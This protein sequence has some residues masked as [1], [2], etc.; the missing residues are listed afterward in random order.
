MTGFY[1][2]L[3]LPRIEEFAQRNGFY[4]SEWKSDVLAD[5]TNEGA[6]CVER[7][8]DPRD[9]KKTVWHCYGRR[10]VLHCVADTRAEDT[11]FAIGLL[12]GPMS[13]FG[14]RP[15][16][17]PFQ[18]PGP[19]GLHTFGRRSTT[20]ISVTEHL[21]KCESARLAASAPRS[22]ASAPPESAR[23]DPPTVTSASAPLNV[24]NPTHVVSIGVARSGSER[25]ARTGATG[26]DVDATSPPAANLGTASVPPSEPQSTPPT[27]AAT[28]TAD[29]LSTAGPENEAEETDGAQALE[30]V[31][32]RDAIAPSEGTPEAPDPSEAAAGEG[33]EFVFHE[34][35]A[36]WEG[37]ARAVALRGNPQLAGLIDAADPE[38]ARQ[39][40]IGA[41]EAQLMEL[42]RELGMVPSL[43][44]V[45]ETRDLVQR[46][47]S[48]GAA[49]LPTPPRTV[50]A[51]SAS[52]L[53]NILNALSTERHL[54]LP[55][56]VVG[57]S[58][59]AREVV[60]RLLA[61][62]QRQNDLVGCVEWIR[63][64]FG[65]APPEALRRV[66]PPADLGGTVVE[67]LSRAWAEE[68]AIGRL[69]PDLPPPAV[70]V[71]RELKLA[72]RASTAERLRQW[73]GLLRD[74][75]FADLLVEV[76]K[77]AVSDHFDPAAAFSIS[78]DDQETLKEIST[79]QRARR[80]IERCQPGTP[81]DQL[82]AGLGPT[83]AR[84]STPAV[85]PAITELAHVV[86]DAVRSVVK[87]TL[88]VPRPPQGSAY[89]LVDLPVRVVAPAAI[90]GEWDVCL[91]SGAMAH[92][93]KDISVAEGAIVRALGGDDRELSVR[94]STV[95][96]DWE[97]NQPGRWVAEL[98]LPL[99]IR[100]REAHN[101]RDGK[102]TALTVTL[103]S[104][105]GDSS[106]TFDSF[107]HEAPVFTGGGRGKDESATELVSNRPLGVQVHREKLERHLQKGSEAFMVV[108]PR[109]F[110]KTI[111]F[112]HLASMD[113]TSPRWV[114]SAKLDR[115]IPP[116]EAARRVWEEIRVQC[117][118]QFGA[119]PPL[120]SLDL[121]NFLSEDP[122]RALKRFLAQQGRTSVSLLVDEAQSLVPRRG[123]MQWG[124]SCKRLCEH[125]LGKS[126]GHGATI[127]LG[128]FG[129]VDL[130]VRIGQDCRDAMLMHGVEQ[131]E[132]S[133]DS[134][135]RYLKTVG[136]DR[137]QSSR[138]ARLELARWGNNLRTLIAITDRISARLAR[139]GRGFILQRDV[140]E[141]V[142]EMLHRDARAADEVWGYARSELSHSDKWEPIDAFPMAVAWAACLDDGSGSP[143]ERLEVCRA[144]L[145]RAL[146]ELGV[147]GAV[148][149]DRVEL[150]F[151]D[152]K[153]RGVL[154][155][156][157]SFYRP[158]LQAL[159][160]AKAS[161][162]KEEKES[163][164]SLLR[165]AVD[166]VKWPS[167]AVQKAEGGQARVF[168][169]DDTEPAQAFRSCELSS[170][171]ERKRFARSCAAIRTL[172]DRSST[173]PGDAHL[174]RI[175]QA[176]FREDEPKEGLIVYDWVE[177]ESFERLWRAL[178]APARAHV[179]TQVARAVSALHGREILHCDVAPRNVV[180]DGRLR[181]TLIDFGLAR[182]TD[183]DS[184]T[185]L[186]GDVFKAPEQSG[187][188]PRSEKASD[189]YALGMMLLGPECTGD[190]LAPEI[191]ALGNQM[192]SS[193]PGGRPTAAKVVHALE[194]LLDYEPRLH[195][196]KAQV[197][198]VVRGAPKWLW[199][200][201]LPFAGQIALVHAR[202]LPWDT[203]RA[204]EL[205]C[206][207]NN[208]FVSI[209]REGKGGE[210]AQIER[211]K[212]G[213]ELSLNALTVKLKDRPVAALAQWERVEVKA[214][215]VLRN[216]FA[217]PRTRS[218][219]IEEA[220]ILLGAS[221]SD[222]AVRCR[223]AA[224]EVAN[225]LDD[226]GQLAGHPV[227]NL[228][229]RFAG[230]GEGS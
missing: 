116:N 57:E 167:S 223:D 142:D 124:S 192:I 73:L 109:R 69:A 23:A 4:G 162:F 211:L 35:N 53:M 199:Q 153:D 38:L 48:A 107:A 108:A 150:A 151:R 43:D 183:H 191:A 206:L 148:P 180:V 187:L 129:T 205:A 224:L 94:R 92:V 216:A 25:V 70:T 14:H 177:G 194:T 156:D 31:A 80:H 17:R 41:I 84:T 8:V 29:P 90:A 32:G 111:L 145:G 77:D 189:I 146:A 230:M 119:A 174:P 117:E 21:A 209:V 203:Y 149:A 195:E 11:L 163:Q 79:W 215:G 51:R 217:H 137:V 165:L 78:G 96:T 9:P 15:R 123:G 13:Q 135:V 210:A 164:L 2:N 158:F 63:R 225:Q 91:R 106:I 152:L 125:V 105:G 185:G 138:L 33:D 197:D 59:W 127:Q 130:A 204:L 201:M 227:L 76:A 20:P 46:V 181:A 101:L 7:S 219:R 87:G 154:R 103:H 175:R 172:R 102:S 161:I 49:A 133:E 184:S 89:V 39:A 52:G 71:L 188:Y 88:V 34:G 198:E 66:P 221:E 160:R 61:D 226:F 36:T 144:W 60:E 157:G 95:A 128:L 112:E 171:D 139:E 74:T 134:L 193:E 131:Y 6:L 213:K 75:A 18:A 50:G 97:Q 202:V 208:V 10:C 229:R 132:F 190:G 83:R 30:P 200:E 55:P 54:D 182:R 67:G 98:A 64:E 121:G 166:V 178:P 47:A 214:V 26:R 37:L 42:Q 115:D 85:R 3:T 122:W 218:E 118:T 155:S 82:G 40:R 58:S 110:G 147:A 86:T 222:L 99:P 228:A 114:V 62:E 81:V 169:V 27:T 100:A 44:R 104:T 179:V 141:C 168:I 12:A 159:L 56:W 5:V 113:V 212:P 45:V 72:S 28:D 170:E 173:H 207:L 136:Q 19:W 143:L 220:Q 65:G 186:L 120:G 24:E 176:G 140:T 1:L 22:A 196:L 16:G 93:P 126:G 68:D